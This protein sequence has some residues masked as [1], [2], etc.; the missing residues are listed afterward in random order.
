MA[1]FRADLARTMTGAP[2]TALTAPG[3]IETVSFNDGFK[4]WAGNQQTVKS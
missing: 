2:T 4:D 1:K 3:G